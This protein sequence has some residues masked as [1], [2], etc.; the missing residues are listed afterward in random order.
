[1]TAN[2][3]PN[4]A[5]L[6]SALVFHYYVGIAQLVEFATDNRKVG[7]SNPPADTMLPWTADP[8]ITTGGDRLVNRPR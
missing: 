8:L 5:P 2:A 4:A 1:M 3:L 7:G 6:F